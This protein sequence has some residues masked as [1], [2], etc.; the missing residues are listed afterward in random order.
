MANITGMASLYDDPTELTGEDAKYILELMGHIGERSKSLIS[1]INGIANFQTSNKFYKDFDVAQAIEGYR[2][3][4]SYK[5]NEKNMGFNYEGPRSFV[6]QTDPRLYDLI[7]D[8]LLSNAAKYSGLETSV[9]ASINSSNGH[10]TFV[11]KDNGI[12]ISDEDKELVFKE[13]YRAKNNSGEKGTGFGLFGV[14]MAVTSLGGSIR[15]YD[16]NPSGAVFEVNL[17]NSNE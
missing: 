15:L 4:F 11:V 5:L 13:N 12:G 17:P 8:N 2:K 14:E 7:V 6:I 3:L 10:H 9:T 1:L 16:N